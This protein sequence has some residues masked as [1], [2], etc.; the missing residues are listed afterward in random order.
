MLAYIVKSTNLPVF[1]FQH[2]NTLVPN[3]SNKV[4]TRLTKQR[5]VTRVLPRP[6]KN[7]IK[8]PRVYIG[9]EVIPTGQR[10]GRCRIFDKFVE[11]F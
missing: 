1:V 5:H 7:R 2:G 11:I 4:S 8:F 6:I 9:I 3:I 10:P